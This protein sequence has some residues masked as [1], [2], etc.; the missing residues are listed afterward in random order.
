MSPVSAILKS[1]SL[2]ENALKYKC[3]RIDD[4]EKC[5]RR[6]N[7]ATERGDRGPRT[8]RARDIQARDEK[9]T[10]NG[11]SLRSTTSPVL[12]KYVQTDDSRLRLGECSFLHR[13][14]Q[15]STTANN[16]LITRSEAN[17]PT[18]S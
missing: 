5:F 10:L 7:T 17:A 6:I 1:D 8:L 3:S 11:R 4:S 13:G 14:T 2:H 16:Q 18:L 9:R 12:I 15:H